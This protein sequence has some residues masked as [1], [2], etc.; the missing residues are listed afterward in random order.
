MGIKVSTDHAPAGIASLPVT[1]DSKDIIHEMVVAKLTDP[2]QQLPYDPNNSVVSEEG[3]GR[4]RLG[5]GPGKPGT[6]AP[7]RGAGGIYEP[8]ARRA[9]QQRSADRAR[10]R[11]AIALERSVLRWCHRGAQLEMHR[12]AVDR[13]EPT[14]EQAPFENIADPR[15]ER[16]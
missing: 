8:G 2:G 9:G 12:V 3:K 16:G 10:S 1:N 4:A 15:P 11:L 5:D 14:I 13:L 7:D 6:R